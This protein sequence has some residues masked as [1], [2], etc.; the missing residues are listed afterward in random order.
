[1]KRL[2]VIFFLLL[3]TVAKTAARSVTIVETA[4]QAPRQ[5]HQS[6]T[7]QWPPGVQYI[8]TDIVDG[9][10]VMFVHLKAVV[11]Y[12]T[13]AAQRRHDRLVVNVKKVYPIAREAEQIFRTMETEMSAM[14]R[15]KQRAFV[16]AKEREVQKKYTPVLRQMT[17]SQGKILIKLIDRQTSMTSFEIL[18]DMRGRLSASLWQGVAKLFDADLKASY[19]AVGEDRQIEEI[20]RMIEQGLL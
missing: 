19:D 14:P 5:L 20:I 4:A 8:D 16:A 3:C 9:Q 18:R 6:P 10:E 15:A 13:Q 1:M 12:S 7:I 11:K 2:S 17:F